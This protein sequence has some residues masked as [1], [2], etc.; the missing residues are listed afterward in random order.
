MTKLEFI[1]YHM[2]HCK[3]APVKKYD[4]RKPVDTYHSL[5]YSRRKCAKRIYKNSIQNK[6][7]I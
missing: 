5:E 1:D 4:S 6:R 3:T 7:K 2:Q